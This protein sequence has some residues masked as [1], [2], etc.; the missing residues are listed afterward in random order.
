M[1]KREFDILVNRLVKAIVANDRV[2]IANLSNQYRAAIKD[3]GYSPV[4]I[5]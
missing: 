5:L 2:A 3:N 4:V 1:S